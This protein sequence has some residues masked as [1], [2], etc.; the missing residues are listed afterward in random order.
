MNTYSHT[1]R[2]QHTAAKRIKDSGTDFF[3]KSDNSPQESRLPFN[4]ICLLT[5]KMVQEITDGR[6]D[7]QLQTCP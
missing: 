5:M 7:L 3:V 6:G 2:S 4:C 1:R